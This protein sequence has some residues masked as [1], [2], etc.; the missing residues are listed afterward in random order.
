MYNTPTFPSFLLLQ[1]TGRWFSPGT[2]VSSTNKTYCQDITE[3]L[4]KMALNTITLN[5]LRYAQEKN[6][7]TKVL[8]LKIC[9]KCVPL[10]NPDISG[11]P[12]PLA[13][14]RKN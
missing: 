14:G 9:R 11:I 7:T 3:L 8:M 10:R 1:Q 2:L 6:L 4:L 12:E 13:L 5:P